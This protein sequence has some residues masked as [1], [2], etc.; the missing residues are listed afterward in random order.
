[1]GTVLI[2]GEGPNEI[3]RRKWSKQLQDFE[4][5]E[6][7]LQPIVRRLRASDG[8]IDA[9]ALKELIVLPGRDVRPLKGLAHKAQIA[10]LKA[11]TEGY[12][13]VV[14]ATDADSAD[15]RAHDAKRN[16][17]EA[18]YATIV[19]DVVA[20][21]CV[22]MATSEAWLLTDREAWEA[23]GA[24]DFGEWP[25]RPEELLGASS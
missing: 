25:K 13:G 17:I 21:T 19:N 14:V 12:S 3:G 2:Y 15:R 24:I 22:P 20:V 5:S 8:G 9:K 4:V 10:K 11:G 16:E 18:G 6:G 23:I 7:W 1:M